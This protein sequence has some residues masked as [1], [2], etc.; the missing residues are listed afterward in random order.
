MS[1]IAG[2]F[3]R[4]ARPVERPHLQRLLRPMERRGPHGSGEWREGSIGFVHAALWSTPES[5]EEHLPL[6]D[7]RGE[8]AITA[9]ARIDNREELLGALG[10]DRPRA[11]KLGDGE[12]ILH[13]LH[14]IH[15]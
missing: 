2:I 6:T 12:L 14:A 5:L 13:R 3:F 10:I 8:L 1:G 11:E 15:A 4:D 9:D 7:A